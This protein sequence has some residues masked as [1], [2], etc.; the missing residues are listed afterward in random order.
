MHQQMKKVPDDVIDLKNLAEKLTGIAEN[1][2]NRITDF[3]REATVLRPLQA[4]ISPLVEICL[5]CR[6]KKE[7]KAAQKQ[8][9]KTN[10]LWK[11]H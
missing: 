2:E 10:F 4:V 7:Q 3:E 9:A 8:Q 1:H 5:R 11:L 6:R